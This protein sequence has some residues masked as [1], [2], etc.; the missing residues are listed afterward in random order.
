MKTEKEFMLIFRMQPSNEQP[1]EEQLQEMTQHWGAF[2]GGIAMQGKLVSTHQLGFEGTQITA[3]L[4]S[5]DGF[6]VSE[7]QMIAGNLV[8]KSTSLEAATETAKKCP[9]LQMGG[10]VEVRNTIPM[11]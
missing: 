11:N 1:T 4:N 8:L 9:I 10:S 3:D 6:S 5:H 7:N 2:I